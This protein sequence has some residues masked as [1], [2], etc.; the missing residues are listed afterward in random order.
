MSNIIYIDNRPLI[1]RRGKYF[2]EKDKI[3]IRKDSYCLTI[4]NKHIS[5]KLMYYGLTKAKSFNIITNKM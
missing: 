4:S 3:Y 5:E 2:I 1:L